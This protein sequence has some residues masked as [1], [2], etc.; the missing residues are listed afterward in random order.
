MSV[1]DAMSILDKHKSRK[2]VEEHVA[3]KGINEPKV[4]IDRKPK[5]I[6]RSSNGQHTISE[7]LDEIFKADHSDGT[8]NNQ[9]AK[10]TTIGK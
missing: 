3:K 4:N 9:N 7:T 5:R 6:T 10:K 1:T 8:A 2:T